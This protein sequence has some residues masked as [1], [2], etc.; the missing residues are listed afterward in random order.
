[1]LADDHQLLREGLAS[2]LADQPDIEIVAEA[3]DGEAAVD[4]AL[5]TRPD[6]IVMDVTMP[7]LNGVEATRRI[8]AALPQMRVIGLSMHEQAGMADAMRQAG[9]VDYFPKDGLAEQ[10]VA[11]IRQTATTAESPP[12]EPSA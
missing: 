5:R 11:A 4:L 1:M 6:V 3:A 8:T 7:R 10:L 9:A 12:R 2:L